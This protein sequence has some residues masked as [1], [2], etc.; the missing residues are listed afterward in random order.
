MGRVSHAGHKAN[1]FKKSQKGFTLNSL[2]KFQILFVDTIPTG[3]HGGRRVM[4][5]LYWKME[6]TKRIAVLVEKLVISERLIHKKYAASGCGK[7]LE[8]FP[9]LGKVFV[10]LHSYAL[11]HV[12]LSHTL[13]PPKTR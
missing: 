6:E 1:V 12:G 8:T 7:L 5:Q 4:L 11:L 13:P 3:K 2:L 10:S 9:I